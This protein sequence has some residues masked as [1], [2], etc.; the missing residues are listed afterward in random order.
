[1]IYWVVMVEL[2]MFDMF[3]IVFI[4]YFFIDFLFSEKKVDKK[5]DYI[6]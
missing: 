6:I 1:M 5:Y 2:N 3:F 4:L